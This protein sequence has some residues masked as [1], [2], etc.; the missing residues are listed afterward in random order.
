MRFARTNQ[1]GFT[2]VELLV[3]LAIIAILAA[4]LLATTS[5]A[6][7]RAQRI[8]CVG[9]LHQLGIGIRSFAADNQAYPSCIGG[10]NS[11]NPGLW[12]RQLEIGGFDISKP[13]KY[14]I[15][16][17]VWHC[18]AARWRLNLPDGAIPISYGYNV[19]G[20]VRFPNKTNALGL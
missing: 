11:T 15:T 4:L 10:T 16:E 1:N 5:Q 19:Y 2:L 9:N 6:K 7:G 14:F 20:D 3:V 18:A 17:D 12:M 8:Q 13:K